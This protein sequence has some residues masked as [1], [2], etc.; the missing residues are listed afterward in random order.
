MPTAYTPGLTIS[1]DTV[2]RKE[3]LLPIRG[4]VL[5]SQGQAVDGET[6]IARAARPGNLTS[7][8]LRGVAAAAT[9]AGGS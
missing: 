3:R 5:V 1:A 9:S 6:P 8:N 2:V 7:V 4:E